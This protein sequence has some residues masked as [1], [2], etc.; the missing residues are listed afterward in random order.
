MCRFR[1]ALQGL[2]AS[3]LQCLRC[4][5]Q[6]ASQV[7]PFLVLPLSIPLAAGRTAL[8]HAQAAIGASL[9]GCLREFFGYE[10]LQG[11]A[12]TR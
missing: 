2:L 7:T 6:F 9:E 12:C 3:E 8:G 4:K 1:P 11:V 10:A 5:H